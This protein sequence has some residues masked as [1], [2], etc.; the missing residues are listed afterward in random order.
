MPIRTSCSGTPISKQFR[1][2]LSRSIS[3]GPL[4]RDQLADGLNDAF[5][6]ALTADALNDFTSTSEGRSNRRFPAEWLPVIC[7]LTGDES[8]ILVLLSPPQRAL[9]E[10][11]KHAKSAYAELVRASASDER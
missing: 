9:L 6:L 2:A 10:V 7:A 4:S 3:R 8:P 1:E 11:G 5:G